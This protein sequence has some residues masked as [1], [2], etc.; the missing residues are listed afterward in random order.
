VSDL[1]IDWTVVA[2]IFGTFGAAFAG[3]WFAFLFEGRRRRDEETERNVV[4]GN[5]AVFRLIEYWSKLT[6]YNKDTPATLADE[7][8][9]ASTIGEDSIQKLKVMTEGMKRNTFENIASLRE[10]CDELQ[11][12]LAKMY[13][14]ESRIGVSYEVPRDD[15]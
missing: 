13:P 6:V 10:A 7:N 3:A 11:G 12:A 8:L 14:N 1:N 2:T 5:L 15:E 9:I 4:K